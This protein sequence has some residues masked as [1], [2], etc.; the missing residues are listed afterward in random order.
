MDKDLIDYIEGDSLPHLVEIAAKTCWTAGIKPVAILIRSNVHD[1][2]GVT[3]ASEKV[4]ERDDW[5]I[6]ISA[7]NRSE[8]ATGEHSTYHGYVRHKWSKT[9]TDT[10][11]AG[12]KSDTFVRKQQSRYPM[13]VWPSDPNSLIKLS[14]ADKPDMEEVYKDFR[15]GVR[16]NSQRQGPTTPSRLS[17]R[18]P[19]TSSRTS[20]RVTARSSRMSARLDRYI[21]RY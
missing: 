21:P 17:H 13:P 4:Y 7:K 12:R 10:R 5:H 15:R 19:T 16:F 2:T 9:V 6:T 1:S 20:H 14:I 11:S 8:A 3:R 18:R